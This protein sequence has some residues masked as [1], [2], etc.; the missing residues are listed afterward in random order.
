MIVD[1]FDAIR[2]RLKEQ[3]SVARPTYDY[4]ACGAGTAAYYC[5]VC[6]AQTRED[7]RTS[8]PLLRE[9]THDARNQ[10]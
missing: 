5:V 10:G 9:V 3:Q 6:Y 2:A 7:A 1:D 4:E 8:C